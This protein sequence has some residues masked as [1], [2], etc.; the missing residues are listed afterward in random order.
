MISENRVIAI[1]LIAI[2][3]GGL[4]GNQSSKD[5]IYQTAYEQAVMDSNSSAVVIENNTTMNCIINI[6][7][8]FR[9]VIYVA[10]KGNRLNLTL[11]LTKTIHVG[12]NQIY[13]DGRFS[14]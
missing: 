13:Y 5:E 14:V 1:F 11:I 9:N 3:I 7:G 8:N 4:V 2:S 10:G 6:T 12:P